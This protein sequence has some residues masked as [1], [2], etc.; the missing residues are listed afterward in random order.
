MFRVALARIGATIGTIVLW[1]YA[2][3]DFL[4][5]WIGRSTVDDDA[6]QLVNEKLPA[7]A[8]W[9]FT[10]PSWVP[11]GC[12]LFLT[13][14]LIWLTFPRSGAKPAQEIPSAGPGAATPSVG[15]LEI[16]VA[17]AGQT[18]SPLH[19]ARMERI[20]G[21]LVALGANVERTLK[22]SEN[23]PTDQA[24]TQTLE[25]PAVDYTPNEGA[26]LQAAEQDV[27]Q[28]AQ[29]VSVDTQQAQTLARLALQAAL[30]QQIISIQGLLRRCP[31]PPS[32]S[33]APSPE[34]INEYVTDVQ[35][36]LSDALEIAVSWRL[37]GAHIF[38][39][40]LRRIETGAYN[41]LLDKSVKSGKVRTLIPMS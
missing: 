16:A 12:A 40:H 25:P 2:I 24:R 14:W 4:F 35:A 10:T 20:E 3:A 1:V 31:K 30:A 32:D 18:E 5:D 28:L 38:S 23:N 9:L 15:R 29:T 27:A 8:E 37:P 34:Q 19:A 36:Y 17:A 33:G 7:W 21:L 22:Q 6:A 39:G 41:R 13:G 11:A 26:S